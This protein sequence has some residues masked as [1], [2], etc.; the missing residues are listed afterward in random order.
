MLESF[1]TFCTYIVM[2]NFSYPIRRS[3]SGLSQYTDVK[4]DNEKTVMQSNIPN[5][6][7]NQTPHG[8]NIRGNRGSWINS[9]G[10]IRGRGT[11][12]GRAQFRSSQPINST[13]K[14][15]N[16]LKFENDYDFEQANTKFEELR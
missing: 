9:R 4:R 16:T 5:P 1:I 12:G 3:G 7:Q 14:T 2:N 13:T 15:K 8:Q 10:G 6:S 11:R